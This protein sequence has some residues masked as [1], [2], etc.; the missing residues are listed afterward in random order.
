MHIQMQSPSF[1]VRYWNIS[2]TDSF[3]NTDETS[4]SLYEWVPE[5][6]AQPVCSK[7]QISSE[8]KQGMVFMDESLNYS[9]KQFVQEIN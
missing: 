3:K 8:L 6:F 2:L 7:T 9:L 4:D 1:W 5:F